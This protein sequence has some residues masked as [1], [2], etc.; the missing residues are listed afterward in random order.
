MHN[1]TETGQKHHTPKHFQHR[2]RLSELKAQFDSDLRKTH[3]AKNRNESGL[4]MQPLLPASS[5]SANN[6]VVHF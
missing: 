2:R 3:D 4:S 1:K 6:Y 5:P